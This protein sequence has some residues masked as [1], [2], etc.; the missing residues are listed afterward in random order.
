V[1]LSQSLPESGHEHV[2]SMGRRSKRHSSVGSLIHPSIGIP[3]A[4]D[5]KTVSHGRARNGS[6]MKDLSVV[7]PDLSRVCLVDN[8]PA[9]YAINQ[10]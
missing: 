8:S 5:G 6:Y 9:S 4:V 10:G 3:F 1:I 2:N 7:E